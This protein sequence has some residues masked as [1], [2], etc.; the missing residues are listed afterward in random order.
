MAKDYHDFPYGP[1]D[2]SRRSKFFT[3]NLSENIKEKEMKTNINLHA[4]GEIYM[5]TKI[6]LI[7][8]VIFN[9]P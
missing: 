7:L 1:P 4:L 2:H 3:Q 8:T 5:K 6:T 9:L